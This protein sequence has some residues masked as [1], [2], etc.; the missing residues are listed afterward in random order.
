MGNLGSLPKTLALLGCTSLTFTPHMSRQRGTA[1]RTI[2]LL[3]Q[4]IKKAYLHVRPK[5]N[6]IT[7]YRVL[8]TIALQSLNEQAPQG[9]TI[10]RRQLYFG[11]AANIPWS[12]HTQQD[13][14]QLW[15]EDYIKQLKGLDTL[16]RKRI[17]LAQKRANMA[18]QNNLIYKPNQLVLFSEITKQTDAILTPHIVLK[19]TSPRCKECV[20]DIDQCHDCENKPSTAIQIQCLNTGKKKVTDKSNLYPLLGSDYIS[21][22]LL[23]YVTQLHSRAKQDTLTQTPNDKTTTHNNSIQPNKSNTDLTN[24][25]PTETTSTNTQN[26]PT[27]ILPPL[28]T[29]I[30]S[31]DPTREIILR[32]SQD[33]KTK[34]SDNNNPNTPIQEE[35]IIHNKILPDDKW[36]AAKKTK[37]KATRKTQS[38]KNVHIAQQTK[39]ILKSTPPVNFQF[40]EKHQ[41]KAYRTAIQ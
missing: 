10:S 20:R 11:L 19:I 24:I 16:Y 15:T 4:H 38:H 37:T 27:Q 31:P 36:N 13:S 2:A 8:L 1:E 26:P 23:Q 25:D 9:V 35:W 7:D 6:T 18:R 34:Q 32:H 12:F 41:Q 17:L 14:L 40:L 30:L 39:T 5:A 33:N 21:P 29:E 28:D 22:K 3:R